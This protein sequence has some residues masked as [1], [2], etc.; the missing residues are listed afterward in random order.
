MQTNAWKRNAFPPAAKMAVR[1]TQH[2][3]RRFL[4]QNGN[5]TFKTGQTARQML[6][7][8]GAHPV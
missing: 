4:R 7:L 3:V 1:E 6:S 5:A 2:E 8:S